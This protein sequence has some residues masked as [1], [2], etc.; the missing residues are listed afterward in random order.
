M[1][2]EHGARDLRIDRR[3]LLQ[4]TASSAA[5]LG[6]GHGNRAVARA[7]DRLAGLVDPDPLAPKA[8]HHRPTAQRVLV[9]LSS[10]LSP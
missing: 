7:A 4:M 3:T 6:L 8:P 10:P 1:A 2:H 9:L 5:L